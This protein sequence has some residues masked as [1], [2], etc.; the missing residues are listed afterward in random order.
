MVYHHISSF[1]HYPL[2][3]SLLQLKEM[4]KYN[5]ENFSHYSD[6][7]FLAIPF[8]FLLLRAGSI[9]VSILFVYTDL[10]LEIGGKARSIIL[11]WMVRLTEIH[12]KIVTE[13]YYF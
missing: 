10:S 2:S 4:K 11:Y 7:K 13:L 12:Y 3:V 6:A 5:A 9:V 1:C 8:F